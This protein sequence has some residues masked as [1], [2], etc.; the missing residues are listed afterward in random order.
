VPGIESGWDG[1]GWVEVEYGAGG[2]VSSFTVHGACA[3]TTTDSCTDSPTD[4]AAWRAE[5]FRNNCTCGDEQ[6]YSYRW[7]ELNRLVDARRY[8]RVGGDWTYQTRMR[9]RYDAA[10]QRMVEESFAY[11]AQNTSHR[12][13]L[14]VYPGHFERRGL[15]RGAG[16]YD[17]Q[18]TTT[19]TDAT[20]T[21]YLL[22]GARIVWD[23]EPDT[24]PWAAVQ[25]G[26]G[27]VD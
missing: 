4:S 22:A 3:D 24:T 23:A 21:H 6:H 18:G 26:V 10:N 11:G 19:D 14:T 2:N 8:D 15:E 5:N 16:T 20:E 12:V 17:A 27:R 7:D 13:A 9:Y 1:A 25:A